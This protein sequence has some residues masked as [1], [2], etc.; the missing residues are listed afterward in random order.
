VGRRAA[1]PLRSNQC[2]GILL[3]VPEESLLP[4]RFG[5]GMDLAQPLGRGEGAAEAPAAGTAGQALDAQLRGE[6][7]L[8]GAALQGRRPGP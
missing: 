1:R 3:T 8:V 5:A 2:L 4:A 6:T 7:R